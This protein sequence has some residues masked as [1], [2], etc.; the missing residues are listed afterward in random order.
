MMRRR[1]CDG[2][3]AITGPTCETGLRPALTGR[4][5]RTLGGEERRSSPG[6]LATTRPGSPDG[7]GRS[8][9]RSLAAQGTAAPGSAFPA[10]VAAVPEAIV[11]PGAAGARPPDRAGPPEPAPAPK[12]VSAS[13]RGK[14]H[15]ADHVGRPAGGQGAIHRRPCGF[16]GFRPRRGRE[17]AACRHLCSIPA[18]R[19]LAVPSPRRGRSTRSRQMPPRRSVSPHRGQWP[20][21]RRLRWHPRTS[22]AQ[23]R[24][25]RSRPL[26]RARQ[27]GRPR[28]ANAISRRL[29]QRPKLR[30]AARSSTVRRRRRNRSTC[31]PA[32][33][34][35]SPM[36]ARLRGIE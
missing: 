3:A 23:T 18:N 16:A 26:P 21:P 1:P 7:P 24:L 34:A 10:P 17:R 33:H 4:D 15:R 36:N 5:G 12:G 20:K 2:A 32:S 31:W 27:D 8:R 14:P 6:G 22:R 13:E 19:S 29:P 25:R 35:R 28:R 9:F 30:R 11:L